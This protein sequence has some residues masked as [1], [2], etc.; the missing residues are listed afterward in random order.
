[1]KICYVDESGGTEDPELRDDSTPVMVIT[2]LIL[3]SAD[4]PSITTDFLQL[5]RTFFPAKFSQGRA[6]DHI[7]PEIKGTQIL[8]M[9]RS[10]SRNKRRQAN[11]FLEEILNILEINNAKLL[12][13]IW[14]KKSGQSLNPKSTYSFAIQDFFTYF[15]NYLLETDSEGFVIADSRDHDKNRGVSH[16][17]FTQKYRSGVDPYPHIPETLAFVTSDNHAG[18]QIA[19]LVAS[20]LLFPIATAVFSPE[21]PGNIHSPR[22]YLATSE[23]FSQKIKNLQYRYKSEPGRWVGGITVRDQHG[24]KP[25]GLLFT[26]TN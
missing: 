21:R 19:D 12:S 15:N 1:M 17:I 22:V 10:P 6:L 25:S 2:G 16:S 4:L 3:D 24:G 8:S 23:K 18:I 13:K 11:Q 26:S 7:L 5:K 9:T 20:S 14:V